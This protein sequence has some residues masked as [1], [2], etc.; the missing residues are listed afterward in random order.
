MELKKILSF[1]IDDMDCNFR[2]MSASDVNQ[3]Y[4]EGLK[5][6]H[7]Y[8]ENIPSD[9]SILKQQNYINNTI[10]SKNDT[11]CG[12]LVNDSLIGTAG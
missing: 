8:I 5:K 3:N 7:E 4:V 12:L 1:N 9:V 2:T 6:Q 10:K 11:I